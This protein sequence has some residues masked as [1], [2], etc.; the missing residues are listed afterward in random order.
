MNK[1]HGL[2]ITLKMEAVRTSEKSVYFNETTRRYIQE[3]RQ[4]LV[5]RDLAM[6]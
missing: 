6:D 1:Q 5:K 4:L 3:G 2:F